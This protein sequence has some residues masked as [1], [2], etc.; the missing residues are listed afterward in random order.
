MI[1]SQ[2]ARES[3]GLPN[4]WDFLVMPLVLALVFLGAWALRQMSAPYSWGS[5]IAISLDPAYLPYYALRTTLRMVLAM[6]FS[7]LFTFVYGSA[8]ARS[9]R[10]AVILIPLLDIL[11][12]VPILGFLSITVVG[13]IRLFKGSLLGP[14]AAAIFAIFTSQ[15]WNMAFSFYNSLRMLPKNLYQVADVFHLS[16]WARFWKL[17]VPFAMPGLVWNTMMSASGGWFFVVASEAIS[18]SGKTVMLPG[19]G[20]YI[21]LAIQ[22]RNLTAIGYAIVA[23]LVVIVLYD[24]LL[25][26]PLI[27]WSDK[28]KFELSESDVV[29]NSMVLQAL[30]RARFLRRLRAWLASLAAALLRRRPRRPQ[31]WA[32]R[33]GQPFRRVT[34]SGDRVWSSTVL[35]LSAVSLFALGH[36]IAHAVPAAEIGR[37]FLLGLA[38]AVRVFVLI[39][40]ASLVWVPVGVW[41]GLRPR[42]TQKAQP[43]VLFLSAFPANLL[44]PLAVVAIT[45]YHLNTEV[46]LSPLMILGTQWYILFNVISGAAAIPNDLKEA[47]ANLGLRRLMVWRRLILPAIFPAYVTGGLTAS[48]GAWNASVVSEIVSWGPT[49]LTAT[50]LGAYI[51]QQTAAGDDARIAL[52]ICVMSLYVIIINRLVWNRLYRF[53]QARLTLE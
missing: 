35:A 40:L 3:I 10:A 37:V 22:G 12:S 7:L 44:F 34:A 31:A 46:W 6:A 23:M 27:A 32:Q 52:G 29:P 18:V 50:G 5:P 15:A 17:E 53:A 9:A 45:T 16:P 49:R 21:A 20:S 41:I 28:F 2:E 24:Q 30:Q 51:A 38:T 1:P 4:R 47:A 36:Y 11:Q 19:V 42:W 26:R 14:E 25:F 33:L 13:F 48:G 39:V 8:A 43:I